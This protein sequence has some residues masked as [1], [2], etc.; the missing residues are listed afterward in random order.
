[1]DSNFLSITCR[2]EQFDI[3]NTYLIKFDN[4]SKG[5]TKLLA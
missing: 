5:K 4:I 3:L 1:M 2:I